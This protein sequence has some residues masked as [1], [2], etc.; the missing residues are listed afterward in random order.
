[1]YNL[2]IPLTLYMYV[3]L[4]SVYGKIPIQVM[5]G[6]QRHQKEELEEQMHKI[7]GQLS[8]IRQKIK[9]TVL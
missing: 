3:Q 5:N 7:D 6:H 2:K 1:M 8:R 4:Q 9:R